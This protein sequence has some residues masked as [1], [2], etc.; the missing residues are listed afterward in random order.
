[1]DY[2]TDYKTDYAGIDRL[3]GHQLADNAGLSIG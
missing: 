3:K 1:M 2:K